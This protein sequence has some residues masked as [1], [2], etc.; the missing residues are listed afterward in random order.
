MQTPRQQFVSVVRD[1][2]L[3]PEVISPF[4]PDPG[5]IRETLKFLDL[6]V[7]PD[8]V[9]NEIELSKKLD[10]IPM[11]M[12]DLSG[13]IFPWEDEPALAD[14]NFEV[15]VLPTPHGDWIR[16]TPRKEISWNEDAP[17]PVQTEADHARLV[18]VCEQVGLQADK[19]RKYYR[20]WRTQVG[21][22]GVI[23]IG[24]PHPSWLGYQINPQTIF[25]HWMDFPQT[26]RRSMDALYEASL[27]VMS[28]ALEEGI[29]FMSDSSYGLEMTSPELFRTMDLPYIQAFA[30]WTHE[31]NGLF[32]YHNCGFTRQFILDGT[33]N[34]LGA[35][36]IE[37]IA[38]PPE[39]DNELHESRK[40]LAPRITTKGNLNLNLLREGTPAQ[41][42]VATQS[43]IAAVRGFPHIISTADGVLPETPPENYVTFIH[44]AQQQLKN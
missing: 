38:P 10:Y 27:F 14:D 40:H 24:H 11:F 25:Y 1:A 12:T 39:G 31:R 42:A 15:A 18:Y 41:I 7:T 9:Q 13:L 2:K 34:R 26:F 6:P 23:V 32:W 43:L 22:N 44:T 20:Q 4:L 17:C 36:I 30:Q 3:G 5:V 16:R 29:D 37:T 21:E 33:F 35:D 8:P 28:I 19:I